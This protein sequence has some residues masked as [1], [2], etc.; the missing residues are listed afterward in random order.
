MTS[1][2]HQIMSVSSNWIL[3]GKRDTI[4]LVKLMPKNTAAITP[5]VSP[6]SEALLFLPEKQRSPSSDVREKEGESH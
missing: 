1:L 2:R 5:S 4:V 3:L 6:L